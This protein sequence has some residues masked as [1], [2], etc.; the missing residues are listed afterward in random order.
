MSDMQKILFLREEEIKQHKAQF[1]FDSE[2]IKELEAE[3]ER[4]KKALKEIST[5]GH[6]LGWS[7]AI[8]KAALEQSG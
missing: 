4:F 6:D 8:A 5:D 2:R 1:E 7:T 3:N